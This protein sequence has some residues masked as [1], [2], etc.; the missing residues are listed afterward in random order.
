MRKSVFIMWFS[1]LVMASCGGDKSTAADEARAAA[2][3][4]YSYLI[5]E[6]YDQYVNAIH[7]S[8]N[9]SEAY[10]SEMA[11]LMAQ[12]VY[13]EKKRRNGLKSV[14]ALDATVDD[15]L[16][17][18]KLQITYGDKSQEVISVP[19]VNVAGVWRIR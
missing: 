5:E 7:D 18:V 8:H 11:D 4:Y 1:A 16:A 17:E 15:R 10:R 13:G 9:M 14:K 12:Y 2:E 3:C 6:R 19:L